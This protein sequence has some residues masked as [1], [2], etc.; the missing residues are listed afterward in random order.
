MASRAPK[1]FTL[2][3]YLPPQL[4]PPEQ[5]QDNTQTPPGQPRPQRCRCEGPFDLCW[6]YPHATPNATC[7]PTWDKLLAPFQYKGREWT[8]VE[9][10]SLWP[11]TIQALNERLAKGRME[12]TL[13]EDLQDDLQ[14][15]VD[16]IQYSCKPHPRP[17]RAGMKTLIVQGRILAE[18]IAQDALFQLDPADP[19][20][21]RPD[22]D[23]VDLIS[24]LREH[25][26]NSLLAPALHVLRTL[27]NTAVHLDRDSARLTDGEIGDAAAVCCRC[28]V[29]VVDAYMHMCANLHRHEETQAA[30][31][32]PQDDAP[33]APIP[34]PNVLL[35]PRVAAAAT[36]AAA[37][38]ATAVASTSPSSAAV[39][40]ESTAVAAAVATAT[41]TSAPPPPRPQAL[42]SLH[43]PPLQPPA[44]AATHAADGASCSRVGVDGGRGA[45]VGYPQNA[46]SGGGRSRRDSSSGGSSGAG[47]RSRRNSADG[48]NARLQYNTLTPPLPMQNAIQNLGSHNNAGST[49]G[50]G[51]TAGAAAAAAVDGGDLVSA[52]PLTSRGWWSPLPAEECSALISAA[53]ATTAPTAAPP[54]PPPMPL[55]LLRRSQTGEREAAQGDVDVGAAADASSYA[56]HAS[57]LSTTHQAE[58]RQQLLRQQFPPPPLQGLASSAASRS[59]LPQ[60]PIPVPPQPSAGL[61]AGLEHPSGA[62]GASASA[63]SSAQQRLFNR[64]SFSASASFSLPNDPWDRAPASMQTANTT[65]SS[66][67]DNNLHNLNLHPHFSASS[68]ALLLSP[69]HQQQPHPQPQLLHAASAY[70]T[71]GSTEAGGFTGLINS[72]SNNNNGSGSGGGGGGNAGSSSAVSTSAEASKR[73]LQLCA[74]SRAPPAAKVLQLLQAGASLAATEKS[75]M[76]ALHM[77]CY[78]GHVEAARLLLLQ[79]QQGLPQGGDL[80]A[81]ATTTTVATTATAAA[82]ADREGRTPLWVASQRGNLELVELLLAALVVGGG[83]GNGGGKAAVDAA[84]ASGVTPLRVAAA[85]GHAQVVELLLAAGARVDAADK[86]GFTPL[87]VACA[88]SHLEVV[89]LLLAAGAPPDRADKGQRTPLWAALHPGGTAKAE[90]CPERRAAVVRALLG[91]GADVYLLPDARDRDLCWQLLAHSIAEGG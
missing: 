79:Q 51:V 58:G 42:L 71:T 25:H 14:V 80:T 34:A 65:P 86:D 66:S 32:Q 47:R 41:V 49:S 21:P 89:R 10:R 38:A 22:R 73:L 16:L 74:A 15:L 6:R 72:S 77:A 11:H 39:V 45:E 33:V 56:S 63:A 83:T 78:W 29:A 68:P 36:A 5:S 59:W 62:A 13:K 70:V 91:A 26:P 23:L 40:V 61:W 1:G 57:D 55:S 3:A 50:N 31:A 87:Y 85:Q 17:P 7:K 2:A 75:G 27:G 30:L 64:Q 37:V 18:A 28:V 24:R 67:S 9:L 48:A 54:P 81:A 53:A 60:G 44:T 35:R 90:A 43:P 69:Q 82:A 19:S 12:R 52:R 76:N 20:A 88:R 46:G 4:K 8:I 84:N